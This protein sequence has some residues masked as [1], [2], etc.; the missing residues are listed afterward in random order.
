[1]TAFVIG[2]CALVI[3]AIPIYYLQRSNSRENERVRREANEKAIREAVKDAVAPKD[4]IIAQQ[5]QKI[6]EM[7]PY[8]S[9]SVGLT[10]LWSMENTVCMA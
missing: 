8:T 4:M 3:S 5:A 7:T 6:S 2:I 1:M 10:A 9:P